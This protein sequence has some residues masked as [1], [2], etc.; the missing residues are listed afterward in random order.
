MCLSGA[1]PLS[2]DVANFM[3]LFIG[4][5]VV[6]GYGL[7]ETTGGGTTGHLNDAHVGHVGTPLPCVEV[8]L[9][10]IPDM[11]Y[12]TTDSPN[13][14]GEIWF[15]GANICKGYFREPE[16][17]A[18]AFPNNDGW[19]ATGDV[20]MWLPNGNLKII[21]RKKNIFKLAQGEYIRPEHIENITLM[22]R[23]VEQAFVYGN[24]LERHLVG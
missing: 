24:S 1:A 9:V 15:R 6:E 2:D 10:D 19:F 4:D 3:K 17:T 14:R 7:T 23:Y 22:S 11:N 16:K 5:N 12:L 20:G 21:D 13:P 8:K 18:D